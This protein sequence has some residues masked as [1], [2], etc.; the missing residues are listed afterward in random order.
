M[1][2]TDGST[3]VDLPTSAPNDS[4][5]LVARLTRPGEAGEFPAEEGRYHLFVAGRARADKAA[6]HL[7]PPTAI[8]CRL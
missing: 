8:E 1:I 6:Q 7:L 3:A 4:T 2:V 5:V